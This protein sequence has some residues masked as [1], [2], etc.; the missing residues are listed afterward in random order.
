MAIVRLRVDPATQ[1]Y[2]ARLLEAGNPSDDKCGMGRLPGDGR[3]ARHP[4]ADSTLRRVEDC[5][6]KRRGAQPEGLS[7]TVRIVEQHQRARLLVW[8]GLAR[9]VK[10]RARQ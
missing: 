8:P 2:V 10:G 5:G 4:D 3:I 7:L 9:S 6:A 1:A